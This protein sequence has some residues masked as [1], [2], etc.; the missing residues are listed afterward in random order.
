[1]ADFQ[2]RKLNACAQCGTNKQLA[3]TSSNDG[4]LYF[5]CRTHYELTLRLEEPVKKMRRR[6]SPG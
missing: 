3:V 6:V 4:K 1:M 5:L 2:D